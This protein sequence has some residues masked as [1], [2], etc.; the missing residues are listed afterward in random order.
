M[1]ASRSWSKETL[2]SIIMS[3]SLDR[4]AGLLG[5]L[6]YRGQQR[7]GVE[8]GTLAGRGDVAVALASRVTRGGRPGAG[9]VDRHLLLGP[10]VDRRLVGA[11]VVALER[12]PL[13]R[14][15]LADQPDGLTEARETFLAVRPFDAERHL[16]H[17]LAG[18]HAEHHPSREQAAERRERLRHDRRVVAERRRQH[19]GAH[20]D[21]L[22]ASTERAEPAH[23]ERRMATVVTP[24]LQ[25]VADEH[26]V[27]AALLGEDA[28]VRATPSA[29]TA[30][31]MPCSRI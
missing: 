8:L 27:E 11:V 16:V 9:E 5:A 26:R 14:P 23:R 17:R 22:G 10:V 4:P 28:V 1:A 13:L 21:P 18:A 12:D 7:V 6:A 31:W 24:R 15:Q 30:R 29:R 2:T 25:V 20:R 19:R 3:M